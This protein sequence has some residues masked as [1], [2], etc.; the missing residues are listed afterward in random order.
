MQ[1]KGT[2]APAKVNGRSL[3]PLLHDQEVKD[4]RSAVLIPHHGPLR[5]RADPDSPAHR[6]G[7]PPTYEAIRT[8]T[9]VYVEY[10]TG[11]KVYH[12]LLTDPHELRNT[13]PSLTSE[14]RMRLHVV[15]D[16]IKNC[17]DAKTCQAAERANFNTMKNR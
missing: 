4:W 12:D 13:F 7:N 14:E 9:S 2:V 6:S 17:H 3:V 16:A 15:L 1:K 10:A 11:E 8:R 5:D